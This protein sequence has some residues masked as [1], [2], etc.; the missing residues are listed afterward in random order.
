MEKDIKSLKVFSKKLKGYIE[1]DSYLKPLAEGGPSSN[2][3]NSWQQNGWNN[4]S[5]DW[6]NQG[7]NNSSTGWSN[8]GWNNG[9]VDWTNKGW[10]NSSTNWLNQS[11]S[12]SSS[13][14]CFVTTACVEHMGLA[15]DC[16]QLSIL[17]LFRDKLVE[18]D[19]VFREQVLEYYR[20]APKIV[21]KIMASDNKD[22]LLDN[23]YNELVLPCV[24][25]L[26]DNKEEEAKLHYI[27]TFKS[28]TKK[29]IPEVQ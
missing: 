21:E 18:G 27:G 17:R 12:N 28:L 29:Y 26:K 13:S 23:L 19:A 24:Q 14:G 11:W 4:S 1:L 25:L 22:E 16:E 15:D 10:N 3:F 7:W 8:K 9:S 20:N 2:V 5:T 6:I